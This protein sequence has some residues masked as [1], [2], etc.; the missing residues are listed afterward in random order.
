MRR[1]FMNNLII[2][3]LLIFDCKNKIGKRVDF[4]SGINIITSSKKNG[5]DVGKSVIL[6]S[7]YHTLGA[8]SIFDD[9]WEKNHKIYVVSA[10][11]NGIK[12]YIYRS[13]S[14]FKIFDENYKLLFSTINRTELSK[15]LKKLYKFCILLPNRTN[16]ELE[17]TPP[18][19]SYILNFIDQD[20]MDGT[21]FASFKSL[22]NYSN[23]K[24]NVIY[25]HFGIFNEEYFLSIRKLE[26]LKNKEKTFND[27]K[28]LVDNMLLRVEQY[29]EGLDAPSDLES[30]NIELEKSKKDY[31][32]I[33]IKLKKIKN[34]LIDLRNQKF[35]LEESIE[36]LL[37]A[38]KNDMKD[39]LSIKGD[40]CPVCH[41][42]INETKL[43]IQKNNDV[44]DFYIMKDEFDRYLLEINRKINLKEQEYS[45][46]LDK[47]KLYEEKMN[48]G[49]T[50][51]SDVIKHRGYIE[52]QNNLLKELNE[53]E[54]KILSNSSQIKEA[55]KKVRKYNKLKSKA[56]E[57]YEKY[58]IESKSE[59]GLEEIGDEKLKKVK[60]NFVARGSNKPISTIIW[61]F[62]LLKVKYELN[63]EVIKFP[64]ILDSPNNV[65]LDDDK[66]L[67]L[68]KY[69]FKNNNK[70]AQLILS[71][72]GFKASDYEETKIDKIIELKNSKYH[73]LNSEDY[74][75]NKDILEKI[76]RNEE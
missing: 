18:A 20:H 56:N 65:E 24:E 15:Y 62:N 7:I 10:D 54:I 61:Y 43:I 46:L 59:F 12:Y 66:R 11:I 14:M 70:N 64:M 47:L 69:I 34:N 52:T 8:D 74:N 53:I 5:S 72:L 50:D 31:S 2:N 35:E 33:A 30:L 13:N 23:Y 45:L 55:N 3:T 41:Q 67:T 1:V 36:D 17:I 22:G 39:I 32:E 9:M 4:K 49:N 63:E 29:L 40:I 60:S 71:T 38:S 25:N 58:M 16:E 19:Y 26:K 6:K 27:N 73:L 21:S 75:N 28:K 48:I 42:E 57:L 76:F 68:F 44:E 51:I 37:S